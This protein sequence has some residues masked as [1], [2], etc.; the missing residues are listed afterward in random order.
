MSFY[1]LLS[2]RA[3]HFIF[4]AIWIGAAMMTPGDVKRSFAAGNPA[5]TE[6]ELLRARVRLGSIVAAVGAWGTILS[7]LGLVFLMGGFAAV[8]RAIHAALVVAVV[9]LIVG[10][11][12]LGR[13]WSKISDLLGP[14]PSAVA[15]ERVAPLLRK[16]RTLSMVLKS[17][18]LVVLLLMV[19]RNVLG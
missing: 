4:M 2:V 16:Y 3:L 18:W 8:P 15:H 5:A 17:L 6:L 9:M 11:V 19:F 10:R 1:F 7:G 12:G 14:D 13:S